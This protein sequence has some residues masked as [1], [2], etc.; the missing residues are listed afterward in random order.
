MNEFGLFWILESQVVKSKNST[1]TQVSKPVLGG[2][3]LPAAVLL[4]GGHGQLLL[5][6]L[7]PQEGCLQV[8]QSVWLTKDNAIKDNHCASL[9]HDHL[10]FVIWDLVPIPSTTTKIH[11]SSEEEEKHVY[12]HDH[13]IF[14]TQGA[15]SPIL[16]KNS[17]IKNLHCTSKEEKQT[18]IHIFKRR[19]KTSLYIYYNHLIFLT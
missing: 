1:F 18:F 5:P 11:D 19:T 3:V 15:W 2:V 16:K 13:L 4:K 17:D 6:D 14:L 8:F 10:I 12:M 7:R 9:M